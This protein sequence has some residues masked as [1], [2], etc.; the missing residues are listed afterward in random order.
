MLE[1]GEFRV[2][3]EPGIPPG[4]ER[5][6]L[7]L[8]DQDAVEVAA[9]DPEIRGGE[10]CAWEPDK[11]AFGLVRSGGHFTYCVFWGL[12]IVWRLCRRIRRGDTGRIRS[13]RS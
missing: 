1:T 11:A 13:I 6:A 9:G 5:L 12:G 2:L 3:G 4:D 10:G 8:A 7:A